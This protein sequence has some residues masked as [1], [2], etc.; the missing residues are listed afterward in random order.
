[1][2]QT[3]NQAGFT[4]IELMIVIA[5][6]AI[7]L[8]IAIPA[9]QNYTIRASNSECV[10]LAASVKTAFSETA[11]SN[12]ELATAVDL[13]G[14][15]ITASDFNTDR[16]D[17]LADVASGGFDINSRDNA[18]ASAG[19]FRFIP[20]QSAVTTPIEWECRS[21]HDNQQHVPATC[22]TPFS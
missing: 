22:R 18:G 5:I 6:L 2:N 16:C 15:G 11:Q 9:Y 20:Q 12:G 8:A 10:N 1:M 17:S 3:R 13:S 21:N 4:L 19:T 14:A 7:L